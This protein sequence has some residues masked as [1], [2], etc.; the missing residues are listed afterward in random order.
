M[1]GQAALV[2]ISPSVKEKHPHIRLPV[3]G[4]VKLRHPVGILG[5]LPAAAAAFHI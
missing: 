5:S 4:E 1:A 3:E 2:D